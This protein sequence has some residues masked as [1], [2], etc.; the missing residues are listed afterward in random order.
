MGPCGVVGHELG[1]RGESGS[2]SG[3]MRQRHEL[4]VWFGPVDEEHAQVG[5][6]ITKGAEFPVN[7]GGDLPII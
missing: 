4:I 2:L 5:K 3:R 6:R 1:T 7:D